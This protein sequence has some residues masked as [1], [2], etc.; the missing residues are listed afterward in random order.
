MLKIDKWQG[1]LFIVLFLLGILITVQ[2]R[3]QQNFLNDLTLQKTEDLVMML[4]KLHD[5]RSG[6]EKELQELNRQTQIFQK[7]VSEG[8]VLAENLRHELKRLEI[9]LG[10]VPVKGPGIT[11]TITTE[12]PLVYLDLVDILN[13]LWASG[14]EAIAINDQRITSWTKIYWDKNTFSLTINDQ[15]LLYPCTIKAI[16]DPGQLEAGLRLVGGVLD[17]LAIYKIYPVI[18]R[19]EEIEIPAAAPPVLYYISGST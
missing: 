7:D 8:A 13:E 10:L 16:G 4:K 5:K 19:E 14:A 2:F 18:T 6:L 9:A 17:D 3:T 15:E 12:S 1:Y 11:I